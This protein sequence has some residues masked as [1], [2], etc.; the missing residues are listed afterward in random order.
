MRAWIRGA[1]G[2]VVLLAVA[3]G[4]DGADA[5]IWKKLKEKAEERIEQRTDQALDA[6]VDRADAAVVCV[7]T[8][9]EC[10]A[11]AQEEGKEV[12][13]TDEAGNDVPPPP[14]ETVASAS[15][16]AALNDRAWENYDFVPGERVLFYDDFAAERV[17]NFP[18]GL[19]FVSGMMQVVE[20]QGR[21][22]LRV[23]NEGTFAI[24]LPEALP[25]RFTVE[26]DATL[27][28]Y[29]LHLYTER[30]DGFWSTGDGAYVLLSA[31]DVGLYGAGDQPLTVVSPSRALGSGADE[32]IRV[33][34][35]LHVDGRYVKLYLDEK[36]VANV[37]A[38]ELA[39][40][41]R[42]YF[43]VRA[44][45]ETGTP[46]VLTDFAVNAGGR[47][48]YE[49]LMA[50]G[51]VATRGILFDTGADRIRPESTP[52]LREIGGML[53]D[54][55]ELRLRIEGHTD[56]TGDDAANLRLSAA[57]AAAVKAF[58]VDGFGIAADRLVT[59]GLGETRPAVSNGT[60]E[61]RQQNRRVELVKM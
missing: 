17:G 42:L 44:A 57:R 47:P 28:F 41:D 38:M 53:R 31:T 24:P 13:Y 23:E 33:R 55:P 2:A 52:T 7:V 27:P 22:W 48:M 30:R 39:R 56:D 1:A 45:S 5:Q 29:G 20:L 59:E 6:V 32:E 51:R 34:V 3:G 9:P 10:V 58:L 40:S 35:R 46:I 36:R 19:E 50:D 11:A 4:L 43:D 54:H 25:E 18:R 37:P 49:A 60:P 16:V 21:H 26:F 14:A 12:R 8:D 15:A 61:G